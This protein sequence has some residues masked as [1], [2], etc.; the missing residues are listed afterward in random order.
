MPIEVVAPESRSTEYSAVPS[1]G[2]GSVELEPA[3]TVVEPAQ[4]GA[5]EGQH[6]DADGEAARV[7]TGA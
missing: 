1:E 7:S 3:E 2:E 5:G 4:A 6:A